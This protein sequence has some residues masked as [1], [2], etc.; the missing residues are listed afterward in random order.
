[1]AKTSNAQSDMCAINGKVSNQIKCIS[2][3]VKKH[4]AV[5]AAKTDGTTTNAKRAVTGKGLATSSERSLVAF[6]KL[7]VKMLQ[8]DLAVSPKISTFKSKNTSSNDP[9]GK[10]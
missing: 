4:Q 9:F 5:F 2:N 8:S 6:F 10:N 3:L 1:M 7:D